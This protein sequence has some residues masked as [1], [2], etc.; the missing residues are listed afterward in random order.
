MNLCILR[1][2]STSEKALCTTEESYDGYVSPITLRFVNSSGENQS[3]DSKQHY[4]Y[5]GD[6]FVE[7]VY[8][9]TAFKA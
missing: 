6:P 9:I 1:S 4:Q 3:I 8:P 2:S 5:Q 7:K